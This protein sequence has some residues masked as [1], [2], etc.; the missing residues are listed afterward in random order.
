MRKSSD[1]RSPADARHCFVGAVVVYLVASLVGHLA[2][3]LLQ[4][5]LYTLWRTGSSGEITFAILHCTGG[6]LVIAS[7]SLML[8]LLATA[9][10]EWPQ[11]RFPVVAALAVVTGVAYTVFSEWLNVYV[12]QSW[13]YN[14]TM[15]VLNF[16]SYRIGLAPLAQ[17]LVIPTVAF[18]VVASRYQ[19]D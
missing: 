2:W 18:R 6:D 8:A 1:R 17:W 4:V 10:W 12:R 11:Q 7:V 14:S 16:G 15:P 3:E 19:H 13:S 9:S 5:P